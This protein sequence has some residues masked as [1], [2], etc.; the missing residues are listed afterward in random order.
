VQLHH[1]LWSTKA[2]TTKRRSTASIWI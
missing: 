1:Y 2:I